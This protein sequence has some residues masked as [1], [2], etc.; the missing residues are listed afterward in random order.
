[1]KKRAGAYSIIELIIVVLFLAAFAAVAIPR[2]NFSAITKQKAD[3]LARK[4]TTDLRRTRTLAISNAANNTEGFELYMVGSSPYG[5]YEI[6]NINTSEVVDS[7]T[8]TPGISCTD[9]GSFKFGPFGDLLAGS[10]TSLTVSAEGKTFTI[11]I[12]AATGTV[13]CVE[14]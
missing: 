13:K 1:M 11:S 8:I 7:H 10:D 4:I 2:I 12:I 9:G 5:S 14:N 3:G 6:R